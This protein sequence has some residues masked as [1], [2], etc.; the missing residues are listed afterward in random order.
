MAGIRLAVLVAAV[1]VLVTSPVVMSGHRLD[2][3][4]QATRIA[5]RSD[6]VELD[7]D[8][9]AGVG[10]APDVW[11]M[12]DADRNR[13]ISAAEGRNYAQRVLRAVTLQVDE[14]PRALTLV[15][16]RYPTFREINSG[17]GTIHLEARATLPRANAGTHRLLY[18]NTHRPGM[19]VYLVNA[20]VPA[21]KTISIV[22]QKRDPRQ[23]EMRMSYDVQ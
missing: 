17:S 20:L 7:I 14:R 2:E 5:V 12:V 21:E 19:S 1:G 11:A 16:S 22:S 15:S 10:I 23:T 9:T 4:L 18:R 13:R 3:Y 8:L 6:A